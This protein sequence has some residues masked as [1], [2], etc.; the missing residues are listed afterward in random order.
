MTESLRRV[1]V[2]L[3]LCCA[4]ALAIGLGLLV[5]IAKPQT[6]TPPDYSFRRTLRKRGRYYFVCT[7]HPEDMR[8]RIRV[9]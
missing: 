8:L 1:L 2:L 4:A 7:V 5:G 3:L 6:S 9:R